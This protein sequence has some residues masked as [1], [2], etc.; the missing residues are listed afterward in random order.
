MIS[1][2]AAAAV[3]AGVVLLWRAADELVIGASRLALHLRLS[4]VVVGALVIGFGTSAPEMLVS[5]IAA[6]GGDADVGVGNIIGSNIANLT[7][8]LGT[9]GLLVP[10]RIHAP[11]LRR[12]APL[13]MGAVLLFAV[14]LTQG[15][16]VRGGAVLAV[17]L[18]V[19]VWTMI[20]GGHG[21]SDELAAEVVSVA[22][23]E[24]V[25]PG[26]ESVRTIVGLAL[27]VGGAWVLVWGATRI[28][29]D[30][31]LSG[32]FIGVTLVAI[33]TSLPELVASTA[34]AR[35]SQ[36]ELIVGN[37]LGSNMFN[38]LGVGAIVALLSGGSALDSSL[39]GLENG[40]MVAVAIAAFV[41]MRTRGVFQRVE[42]AV[43]LVAYA[44]FLGLSYSLQ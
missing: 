41:M 11:V 43:L 38:S 26:L 27:T 40:V 15:L 29:D 37:L 25:R 5:G 39:A 8:I 13:S 19:A 1:P 31:G 36:T 3:A 18:L 17:A 44:G 4:P 16:T 24:H 35:A 6:A 7:L 2:L 21:G 34:A 30:L 22:D 14:A 32:G 10:I 12:E 42:G 28:A 9:V 33:G 23:P 20:S